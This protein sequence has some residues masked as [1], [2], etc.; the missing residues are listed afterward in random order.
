MILGVLSF[1]GRRAR[2]ISRNPMSPSPGYFTV[3]PLVR[4]CR[5]LIAVINSPIGFYRNTP[6]STWNCNEL[7]FCTWRCRHRRFG[8]ISWRILGTVVRLGAVLWKIEWIVIS[9]WS[10]LTCFGRFS[11]IVSHIFVRINRFFC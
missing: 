7:C 10:I 2:F 5:N 3:C 4:I 6:N 11:K 1:A 9:R 8:V